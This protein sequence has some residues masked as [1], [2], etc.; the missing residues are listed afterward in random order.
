MIIR[1]ASP[2]TANFG[3]NLTMGAYDDTYAGI[4]HSASWITE[5]GASFDGGTQHTTTVKGSSVILNFTGTRLGMYYTS[6]RT[7]SKITIKIDNGTP[8]TLNENSLVTAYKNLW[9]SSI[10]TAGNHK[11]VITILATNPAKTAVNFDRFL[12]DMTVAA[13]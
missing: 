12:V 11:A 1:A 7:Y 5:N 4:E 3:T 6:G 9:L 13:R 2:I 10:L 8:Y